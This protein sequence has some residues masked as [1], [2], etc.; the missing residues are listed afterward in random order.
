MPCSRRTYLLI[1]IYIPN[2][3]TVFANN[4][5]SIVYLESAVIFAGRVGHQPWCQKIMIQCC[6]LRTGL[7]YTCDLCC[8]WRRGSMQYPLWMHLPAYQCCR[9]SFI[10]VESC[11]WLCADIRG[12][13]RRCRHNNTAEVTGLIVSA[14]FLQFNYPALLRARRDPGVNSSLLSFPVY[15]LHTADLP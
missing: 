15:H 2:D 13:F 6:F 10:G 4:S 14:D 3:L 11:P 1:P 7:L 5:I 9:S 12:T 8:P